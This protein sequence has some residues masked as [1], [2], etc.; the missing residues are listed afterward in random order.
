[1]RPKLVFLGGPPRSGTTLLQR[2]LGLHRAIY[3]G[4]EF[5]FVLPIVRLRNQMRESVRSGRISDFTSEDELNEHFR[6]F[7]GGILEGKLRTVAKEVICEKSPSNAEVMPDILEIFK[8]AKGLIILRDPRDVLASLLAVG[9]RFKAA[10]KH[11]PQHCVDTTSGILRYSAVIKPTLDALKRFPDRVRLVFYEDL[12][13][14]PKEIT[15]EVIDFLGLD[16]SD[17]VMNIERDEMLEKRDPSGIWHTQEQLS[18]PISQTSVG[19]WRR[20]L[21][22]NDLVKLEAAFGEV[23]VLKRYFQAEDMQTDP[24]GKSIIPA[25]I[26]RLFL[27]ARNP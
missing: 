5:D 10:G 19:N 21:S 26:N 15:T 22:E 4:Q 7:L 1:M 2:I 9:E 11:A 14:R 17:E 27:S 20:L 23:E 24:R 25:F 3:A 6:N 16:Q 18:R 8:E 12:V 13:A